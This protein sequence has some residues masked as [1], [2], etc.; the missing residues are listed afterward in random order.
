M[1]AFHE[2]KRPVFLVNNY[3]RSLMTTKQTCTTDPTDVTSLTE[4]LHVPHYF[5]ISMLPIS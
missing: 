1:D 5:H 4:G 3:G 2:P